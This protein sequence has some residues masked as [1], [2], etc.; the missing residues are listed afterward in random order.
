M[1]PFFIH[2][3]WFSTKDNGNIDERED[4]GY[5]SSHNFCFDLL[6]TAFTGIN[7]NF[8]KMKRKSPCHIDLLITCH[9]YL[10]SLMFEC[11]IVLNAQCLSPW[12]TIL[13]HCT[14]VA[15]PCLSFKGVFEAGKH[16]AG[17]RRLVLPVIN[18]SSQANI[19]LDFFY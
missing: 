17:A 1:F 9:F 5:C 6:K 2:K 7:A 15:P 10:L 8:L 14:L 3:L 16:T 13:P 19:P 4:N 11:F 18:G 12:M